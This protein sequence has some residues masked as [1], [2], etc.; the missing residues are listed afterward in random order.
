M[1][2]ICTRRKRCAKKIE[3]IKKKNYSLNGFSKWVF[4]NDFWN[5][6]TQGSQIK[7]VVEGRVIFQ[8]AC[9][10]ADVTTCKFPEQNH[11]CNPLREVGIWHEGT[12]FLGI[13]KLPPLTWSLQ[14]PLCYCRRGIATLYH[15]SC[16][17]KK[18]KFTVQ[19]DS[20]YFLLSPFFFSSLFL[21]ILLI[22]FFSLLFSHSS[23]P[24]SIAKTYCRIFHLNKYIPSF[25]LGESFFITK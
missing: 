9:Y 17:W 24:A 4:S 16:T 10:R 18:L 14:V 11:A 1:K 8:L 3:E 15:T 6:R 23:Q 7:L 25:F 2:W 22:F 13:S 21:F 5:D 20:F 19:R 12:D